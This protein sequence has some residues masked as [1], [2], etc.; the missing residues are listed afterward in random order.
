[1]QEAVWRHKQ[2]S[3]QIRELRPG[4]IAY[5]ISASRGTANGKVRVVR[6][7]ADAERLRDGGYIVVIG[8]HKKDVWDDVITRFDNV[9]GVISE[10]GSEN[11]HPAIVCREFRRPCIMG[12]M[13]IMDLVKDDQILSME[14]NSEGNSIKRVEG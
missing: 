13:G 11:S 4:E 2:P 7:L 1:M 14:V 3:P 8:E 12:V 9:V 10:T 5:G 6:T